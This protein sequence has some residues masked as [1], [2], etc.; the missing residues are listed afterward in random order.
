MTDVLT[1]TVY[2]AAGNAV[3]ETFT[4]SI[5][6]QSIRNLGNNVSDANNTMV[7]DM[8][9]YGAA[10][11]LHAGYKT[12]KLANAD[13]RLDAYRHFATDSVVYE[14]NM[15]FEGEGKYLAN[16]KM[17]DSIKF[18]MAFSGIDQT[19]TATVTTKGGSYTIEGK[20]FV[21]NGGYYVI[22]LDKTVM[23]DACEDVTVVI[24]DA[25]GNTVATVTDS[26]AS[27]A[28]R[29]AKTNVELSDAIM[30]FV[31]SVKAYV[32]GKK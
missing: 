22:T 17:V 13:E 5:L 6:E 2:D 7:M 24:T 20:D 27:Y 15:K 12:D 4:D 14:N 29:A 16:V 32:G 25:E 23:A 3:T 11:Q 1:V 31:T 10:A 26:I 28:A 19:M 21:K 30:K 9:N 8:L 18:M